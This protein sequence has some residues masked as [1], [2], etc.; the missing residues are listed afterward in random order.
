MTYTYI[1]K[2]DIINKQTEQSI[3][4]VV[5]TKVYLNTLLWSQ[6]KHGGDKTA[7]AENCKEYLAKHN[8]K[9]NYQGE[10]C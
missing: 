8:I 10:Y 4:L 6:T 7:N 5:W 3:A 1:H 9:N 2:Y